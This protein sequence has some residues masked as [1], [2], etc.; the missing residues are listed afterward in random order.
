[1]NTDVLSTRSTESFGSLIASL[2]A[3]CFGI[4]LL[5]F[6]NGISGAEYCSV[7]DLRRKDPAAVM[8][9]SLDG[10]GAAERQSRLY[11][12]GGF[13]RSDPT[14]S[15]LLMC[16]ARNEASLIRLD[17]EELPIG[18]FRDRLFRTLNIRERILIG[19]GAPAEVIGLSILKSGK[20]GLFRHDDIKRIKEHTALLLQVIAKHIWIR[21]SDF[22]RALGSLERIEKCVASAPEHLPGR[23]AEV[24]ARILYGLSGPCIASD[25][26]I[27]EQ[28]V[29]TYRKRIYLR[30]GIATQRELLMW[31]AALWRR[32]RDAVTIQ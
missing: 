13:W 22:S 27:G 20:G 21:E 23:E 3:P 28:T 4:Q 31:Y 18:E 8:S 30:L 25:L 12:E 11:V 24:C 14:F 5:A 32:S 10:T 17:V 15:E 19:G 29:L 16:V 2:G 9:I 6:L 7:F 1:V 26:G